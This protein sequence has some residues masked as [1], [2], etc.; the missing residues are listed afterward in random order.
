MFHPALCRLFPEARGDF[1]CQR[2][3]NAPA[4]NWM[5]LFLEAKSVTLR[6]HWLIKQT[7]YKRVISTGFFIKYLYNSLYARTRRNLTIIPGFL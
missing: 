4:G 6:S 3:G 5:R 2:F 7:R 1:H